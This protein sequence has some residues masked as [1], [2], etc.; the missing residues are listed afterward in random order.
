MQ[1]FVDWSEDIDVVSSLLSDDFF[2][3]DKKEK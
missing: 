2:L 3:S 1:D